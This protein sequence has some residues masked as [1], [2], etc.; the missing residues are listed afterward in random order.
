[1]TLPPYHLMRYLLMVSLIVPLLFVCRLFLGAIAPDDRDSQESKT[2]FTPSLPSS[3]KTAQATMEAISIAEYFQHPFLHLS[4][5]RYQQKLP[6]LRSY[7]LYYGANHRPDSPQQSQ[8]LRIGI[9]GMQKSIPVLARHKVFLRYTGGNGPVRWTILEGATKPD[10]S[11]LWLEITPL[12]TSFQNPTN[13]PA[14]TSAMPSGSVQ[15]AAGAQVNVYLK[16]VDGQLVSEPKEFASFVVPQL[17]LPQT[18]IGS[19][20]WDLGPFRADATLFP[21]MGAVWF[22][23]DELLNYFGDENDS[24]RGK[25]LI[26]FGD[27]H[28]PYV[29][30]AAPGDCFIFIENRFQPVTPGPESRGKTLLTLV[31]AQSDKL[32]FDLWDSS[33]QMKIPLELPRVQSPITIPTFPIRLVGARS[34]TRW[35]AELNGK[36]S[37]IGDTDWLLLENG[38]IIPITSPELLE[39]YINGEKRGT[40]LAIEGAKKVHNEQHLHG[41]LIDPTRSHLE[42]YTISISK[43]WER[44]AAHGMQSSSNE[45]GNDEEDE[46][47][48]IQIGQEEDDEEDEQEWAED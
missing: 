40:L 27:E 30:W 46:G 25:E 31:Q 10:A 1:M 45:E 35:I 6:D 13:P 24:R 33:G 29:L 12:A 5:V 17:P 21:K 18:D 16:G 2:Q 37:I 4:P 3:S 43:P 23:K 14:S 39:K 34:R 7:I 48:R 26:F 28:N 22:G 9:R 41:V 11:S 44:Q 8:P 38:E 42:P 47:E 20:S 19:T 15:V 36:R 32:I